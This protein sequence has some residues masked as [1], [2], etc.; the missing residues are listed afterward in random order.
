MYVVREEIIWGPTSGIQ[1]NPFRIIF[2]CAQKFGFKTL[3]RFLL[4]LDMFALTYFPVDKSLI[5]KQVEKSA[6]GTQMEIIIQQWFQSS[7]ML[8]KKMKKDSSFVSHYQK[9]RSGDSDIFLSC[10]FSTAICSILPIVLCML[11][12][13]DC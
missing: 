1:K 11:K 4:L 2:C 8:Q 9:S 5:T 13:E 6:T 3:V 7:S 10:V 12:T